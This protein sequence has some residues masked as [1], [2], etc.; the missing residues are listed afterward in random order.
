MHILKPTLAAITVLVAQ[1]AS[2]P[3][4][5]G[6]IYSD[7]DYCQG[8]TPIAHKT[9]QPIVRA[10]LCDNRAMY[11]LDSALIVFVINAPL[12]RC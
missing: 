2:K 11:A 4:A 1:V 8:I 7:Y 12:G 9:Y 3:S 5:H 6:D 10:R